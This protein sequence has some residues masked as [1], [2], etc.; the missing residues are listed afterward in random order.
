MGYYYYVM[1]FRFNA[2]RSQRT[3]RSTAYHADNII[4][5]L[6]WNWQIS[7]VPPLSHRHCM[8]FITSYFILVSRNTSDSLKMKLQLIY[9]PNSNVILPIAHSHHCVVLDSTTS[10]SVFL[11]GHFLSLIAIVN[12]A[13]SNN[14]LPTLFF[15]IAAWNKLKLSFLTLKIWFDITTFLEH[16]LYVQSENK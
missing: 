16:V 5:Q 2:L 4:L 7:P 12:F 10:N 6:P 13:L 11:Q 15:D 8:S 14:L 1:S 9:F 3:E